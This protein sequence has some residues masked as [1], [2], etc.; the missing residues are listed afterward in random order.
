M[1]DAPTHTIT[2]TQ[3]LGQAW[4]S[5]ALFTGLDL[6]I[7]AGVTLVQGDE[8][9]GKTTLLRILSGELAPSSGWV[10]TLGVRADQQPEAYAQKVFRT[11][12]LDTSLDPISPAQWFETLPSRYP[13]FNAGALAELVAGFGLSPHAHKPLY[14]LSAGSRRKVWLSAA[15][16]SGAALVLIDQPFAALDGPSIRLLREVL[17]DFS[18]QSERACVI[19]DYEAPEGVSIAN[20][21][22]L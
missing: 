6:S 9:T 22:N 18:E 3:Q 14:M 5:Q 7:P 19:A 1:S 10:E 11:N 12:P 21:V 8:Q 16:A 20:T 13:L 17:Q 15:F 4:G 2:R